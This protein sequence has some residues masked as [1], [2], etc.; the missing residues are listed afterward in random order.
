MGWRACFLLGSGLFLGLL[1]G[2]D[3]GPG[4]AGGKTSSAPAGGGGSAPSSLSGKLDI[5]GSSTVEPISIK[6]KELFNA[7]HPKVEFSVSGQGTSNGFEALGKRECDICDASRPIKKEELD[8]MQGNG[9]KFV[10]LPVAFDGL[11]VVVNKD[12]DWAKQLTVDQLKQIFR[13]DF[14]AKTWKDI[15]PNWP[16]QKIS[17]YAPGIKSGTHDFFV[18]VIGK[19]DGKKLRSDEQTTLSEDDKQLAIGVKG[20]KHAIGFFGYAYFEAAK[21][22]LKAVAIVNPANGEAVSP[23]PQTIESNSYSP[24]SRPLFW[25]VNSESMQRAEVREFIDFAFE[26]ISK[27]VAEAGYVPLPAGIYAVAQAHVEKGLAGPHFL[28]AEGEQRHGSLSE[29]Y[30]EANL[31]K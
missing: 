14:A 21:N 28:T 13:E 6:A 31:G 27:I 8:R 18:E 17:I 25:Y 20:D 3:S 12:N 24:L 19:K 9:T 2:C 5:Q 7:A 29:T 11:T 30:T 23:S 16:D 22:D 1:V 10:E 4:A 15:D 26:N